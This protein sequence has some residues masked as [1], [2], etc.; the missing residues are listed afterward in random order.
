MTN[1]E[2]MQEIIDF[3]ERQKRSLNREFYAG[4]F[5]IIFAIVVLI[6][7]FQPQNNTLLF[8]IGGG[9]VGIV[10]GTSI[11]ISLNGKQRI[12]EYLD[13]KKEVLNG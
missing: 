2:E 12:Q 1:K 3:A 9:I 8:I 10:S 11:F 7:S 13:E 6:F 4:V 5:G